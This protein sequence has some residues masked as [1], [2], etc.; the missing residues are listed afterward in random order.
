MESGFSACCSALLCFL[1]IKSAKYMGEIRTKGD[2]SSRHPK[3]HLWNK[4]R[5]L[6]NPWLRTGGLTSLAHRVV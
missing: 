4:R 5:R 3:S 2:D 6:I 1:S